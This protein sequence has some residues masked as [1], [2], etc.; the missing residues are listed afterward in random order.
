MSVFMRDRATVYNPFSLRL[1][2][3]PSSSSFQDLLGMCEPV[4]DAS[5]WRWC[6]VPCR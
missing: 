2:T 6:A 4:T 5:S 3:S 1:G